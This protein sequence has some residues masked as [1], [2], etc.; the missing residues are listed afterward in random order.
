VKGESGTIKLDSKIS[1][2]KIKR[3]QHHS[4]GKL[5]LFDTASKR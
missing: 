3:P 4:I 2:D 5:I 1:S